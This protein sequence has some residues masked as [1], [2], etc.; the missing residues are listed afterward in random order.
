VRLKLLPSAFADER[1]RHVQFLT[2]YLVN[3]SLAIDAGSLGFSATVA[4]QRRVKHV[5]I[6]HSH[7]DHIAS[8]PIFLE[9]INAF[10]GDCVTI[11]GSQAVL[12][13]LQKHVFNDCLW[14]NLVPVRR[15]DGPLFRF[16]PLEAG[17]TIELEGVRVTPVP[18]SHAV[19]TMGFLLEQGD[20]AAAFSMDTGPTEELWRRANSLETLRAV[21]LE[22]TF[23]DMLSHVAKVA[24]HMTTAGFAKE[25][26][27]VKRH[28]RLFAIHIKAAYYDRVVS[29]L[30]ALGL[31]GLEICLP[32]KEYVF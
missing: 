27:K 20:A 14:P 11:H 17:H 19:P 29:E 26:C 10:S 21:F 13:G 22:S 6:S 4:Q 5:L 2:T 12:D 16:S 23:P 30:G 8:L 25:T 24:S 28:V 31:P 15:E 7:I 18:V 9:N 32:G 1:G 3:D